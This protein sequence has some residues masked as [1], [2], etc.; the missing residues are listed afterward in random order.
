MS[1]RPIR[2]IANVA[3]CIDSDRTHVLQ[4]ITSTKLKSLGGRTPLELAASGQTDAVVKL[5]RE[6]QARG[7]SHP[8]EADRPTAL[9]TLP[10]FVPTSC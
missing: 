5:L 2:R 4:W 7:A 10:D 3:L 9:A 6:A 8:G 1:A